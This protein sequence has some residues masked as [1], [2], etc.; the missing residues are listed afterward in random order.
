MSLLFATFQCSKA[1]FAVVKTWGPAEDQTIPADVASKIATNGKRAL[2]QVKALRIDSRFSDHTAT[3][4][5]AVNFA[6]VGA[7]VKEPTLVPRVNA[8][9]RRSRGHAGAHS[10]RGLFGDIGGFFEDAA[11]AVK[12]TATKAVGAVTGAATKAADKVEDVATK[13]A[14]GVAGVATA[15]GGA[16]KDANEVSGEKKTTLP[17]IDVQK[18][19]NLAD[20]SADCGALGKLGLKVDADVKAHADVSVGVL[21]AGTVVPPNFSTFSLTAGLNGN[22]DGALTFAANI[23][24]APIDTGKILLFTVGIPG[25]DIPGIISVGPTFNINARA[26]VNIAADA[27]LKVGLNYDFKDVAFAFPPTDK[28]P[29]K[30]TPMPKNNQLVLAV[31]PDINAKGTLTAHLIPSIDFGINALAGKAKATIFFA[32]DASAT[33]DVTANA[34]A[35]VTQKIVRDTNTQ[36][37]DVQFEEK[38]AEVS[39]TAGG[40][41]DVKGGVAA[42]VGADANLFGLFDVNK[43]F[44]VFD[45]SFQIFQ[46]CFG[47]QKRALSAASGYRRST[48]SSF[49]AAPRY[50]SIEAR[51]MSSMLLRR[52]PITFACPIGAG[53]AP[54]VPVVDESVNAADIKAI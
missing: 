21:A 52:D 19:F 34:G 9:A 26:N 24:G 29:P 45:K 38:R 7:S 47:N 5:G 23:A 4:H 20:A 1:P 37:L 43:T 30:G 46:K 50:G 13:A 39:T 8:R 14:T 17:P 35:K 2:P 31:S 10:Q 49:D 32:V 15:A 16:I 22:I 3:T 51:E 48:A 6:V 11:G 33:A 54:A 41:V 25:L 28:A 53:A 12:D 18:S 36:Q 42:T 40:C 44:P 27:K